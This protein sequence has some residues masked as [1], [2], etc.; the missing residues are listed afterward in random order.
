VREI[1]TLRAMWRALETRS[2]RRFTRQRSTLPWQ[3]DQT[4]KIETDSGK[5]TRLFRFAAGNS[6][7]GDLQGLSRAEWESNGPGLGFAIAGGGARGGSSLKVTTT[8]LRPGYLTRN[9]VP[10]SA[11]AKLTEYYDLI[12]EAG[13]DTYLVLTSTVEDPTYLSQPWIT[14]VHFKKQADARGWNPSPC[15]VR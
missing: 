15:G 10:Y 12:K 4:L 5:Q 6:E 13:G 2:L 8:N 14:A 11:N 3:D 7:S 1:R 9:G